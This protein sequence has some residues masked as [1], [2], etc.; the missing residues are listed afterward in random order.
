MIEKG[1]RKMNTIGI[2]IPTV[3]V[4]IPY[5]FTKKSLRLSMKELMLPSVKKI[6]KTNT[7][8]YGLNEVRAFN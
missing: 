4:S 5:D 7:Q 8:N 6:A 3:P 2:I 1:V